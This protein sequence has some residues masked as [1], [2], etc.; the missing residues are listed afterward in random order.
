[1]KST[2]QCP[3]CNHWWC[4]EL[5]QDCCTYEDVKCYDDEQRGDRHC[6]CEPECSSTYGLATD[7]CIGVS[8]RLQLRATPGARKSRRFSAYSVAG[9][10]C[11][12][13]GGCMTKISM[14]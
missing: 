5:A 14:A 12:T 6:R 4:G 11:Q 7:T 9:V 8:H 10:D 2:K 13:S 3:E 1:M